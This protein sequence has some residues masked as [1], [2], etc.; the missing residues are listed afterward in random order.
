[1]GIE[2]V[3]SK[4]TGWRSG[5]KMIRAIGTVRDWQIRDNFSRGN[6]WGFVTDYKH[7]E[8]RMPSCAVSSGMSRTVRCTW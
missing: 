4:V 6:Q 8:N 7:R 5:K 3:A 2:D 1:M